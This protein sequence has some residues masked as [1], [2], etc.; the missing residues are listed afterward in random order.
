M[1]GV[2]DW[3]ENIVGKGENAGYQ[4]FS[5]FVKSRDFFGK[6][7]MADWSS[8][9]VFSSIRLKQRHTSWCRNMV[10]GPC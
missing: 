4:C 2:T 6:E 1:I 9:F 8:C 3:V 5:R 7:F 10:R